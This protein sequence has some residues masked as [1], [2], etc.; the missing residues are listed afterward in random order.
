M[1]QKTLSTSNERSGV[2]ERRRRNIFSILFGR[3]MVVSVLLVVQC[4]LL[5]M[6]FYRLTP[7]IP[8]Y[9]GS[10]AVFTAIALVYQLNTRSNPSVKLSWCV[11][12]ALLPVV[13]VAL[14]LF[15][16]LDMGHRLE[17]K[18]LQ[19]SIDASRPFL[20]E[21]EALMERLREE[22]RGVHNLARYTQKH[23][24][25]AVC[26]NTAVTYYPLGEAAFAAMKE[27]LEK[28]E[29]FIFLEFFIIN[30]GEMWESILDILRRKAA[31]GVEVRVLYDGTCHM[32]A[33]PGNFPKQ[34]RELGIRCKTFSPLRPFVSTHY[35][36]RD[37]RKILLIDG[38]V[39]FTG[40]V[41]IADRY[42]NRERIYGHWKDSAVMLRGDA[43]RNFT[44]M[45]LQMWNADERKADYGPY[46]EQTK[47]VREAKGYVIAYSDSPLDQENVGEMVYLDVLNQ[48]KDYVYIMTPYLILDHEMLTALCFAAR[49]GVDVR[50]MLPHVPDKKYAFVLA[51]SHYP[52]LIEAG[53]R[54]FEYTPGFVHAKSFV[55]DDLRAVV[56]TINLDYRSL[57]LHFE[58]AAYLHGVPA[59][60]DIKADFLQTQE[61]CQ[62]VTAESLRKR[63]LRDRLL[64]A[65]LKV[66]APLM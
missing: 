19:K 66:A 43:V 63:K 49:R 11:L 8:Y 36:N 4:A 28:A 31:Q 32:F 48:A 29:K 57:Y 44:L 64:A 38:C 61:T 47:P 5:L 51:Q 53:V 59:I 60:G 37:H 14:Y 2:V 54:V 52:E 46:L 24:G 16:H 62:E 21:P 22:E 58:C 56:G 17:Q 20:S 15:L 18:A 35:N 23:G 65:V 27:E 33:L 3:T 12:I 40:G 42:I 25:W 45:F 30:E 10:V 7:Y 41:N 26:A 6:F 34:L 9:F 1:T 50:I 39:A 13:G 55:S